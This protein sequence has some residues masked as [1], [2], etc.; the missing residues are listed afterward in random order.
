MLQGSADI[1]TI[2]RED[3]VSHVKGK[4]DTRPKALHDAGTRLFLSG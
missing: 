1:V 3:L 2:A 4:G